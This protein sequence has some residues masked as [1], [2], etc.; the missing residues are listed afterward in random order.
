MQ[1]ASRLFI[2]ALVLVLA[3][4]GLVIAAPA[5]K[6]PVADAATDT[7][8]PLMAAEFALQ[9][10]RLEEAS[11]WYLQAALAA[12]DEALT[13]RA[14]RIALLA[15]DDESAAR[16]LDLW[17]RQGGQ[18]VNFLGAEASLALR[19]GDERKAQRYLIQLLGMPGDEGWRQVLGVMIA[20]A[21][22]PSQAA[23]VLDTLVRRGNIPPKLQAW[24]AF[25]G[26][27]QRLEQ[28][29][30]AERIVA[31]VVKR[32]PGEPRV[33][34][35][36]VSQLR[37]AGRV[38]EA[39]EV[40]GSIAERAGD[41]KELR[42]AIAYEYDTLGD[43]AA[44]EATLA[45]GEQDDQT[46]GLRASLLA[47]AKDNESLLALYEELRARGQVPDPRRRLLLGQVAEFLRR[48]DEALG[49]YQGVP[50]GEQRLPALLRSTNVLHE[51]GRADEAFAQLHEMQADASAAD[52]A[53]RDAYLLEASLHE[54]DKNA[55][56]EKDAFSRGLA[57]FPDDLEILYA[58][59]LSWERGDD[60][61]RAE[62]DLR[63]I[64][65][66]DPESVAALNALGYTLADRTDRYQEALELINRAR[67]AE[68]DNAAI[69]DSY[70][71]VLYRLGRTDEALVALRQAFALQKD[72]EIAAHLA[73]V[74][75]KLGRR[76]EA[77]KY[78]EEAKRID[79]D[80]RALKRVLEMTAP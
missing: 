44:A 34:L 76:D 56:A 43:L 11:R 67:A 23:G 79:P 2:S 69:T 46:Y 53:R 9:A 75:W 58:R 70:G 47:R 72:A 38:E 27:A 15:R 29:E 78:V 6:G 71:W 7:L 35:L 60:V 19:R 32:F 59:A 5:P 61:P 41:D 22:D 36:R 57:A 4:A 55:A 13:E 80:N 73:E 31:E 17:R 26:L 45:R 74:L 77:R 30:L 18:S 14:T 51:L 24:L 49:W 16:L 33:A 1:A 63:R 64:L 52:T 12:D 68:P 66:I 40:L 48:Y 42:L 25:G 8:E 28:P 37:E 39:R 10:G 62:A 21:R 20:G 54:R 65:V 3:S 50:G